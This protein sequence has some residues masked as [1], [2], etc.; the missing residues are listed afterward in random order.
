MTI[1]LGLDT[2]GTYTDAVVMDLETGKVLRK[3]KSQTT[4]EDLSIGIRNAISVL[5]IVGG[6]GVVSLSSTLATNSVVEGKGCRVALVC[7]GSEY[8]ESAPADFTFTVAGAHDLHGNE[9]EALD[10]DSVRGSL[11][12]V[13][14]RVDGVAVN[15]YMA[16][17]NPEHE[18]RVRDIAH[19]ILDVPVVCG[20][21]LSSSL[22]FNERAATCVMNAR[23]IPVIDELIRSVKEVM[24]EMGIHAP[25]MIV[26]GDGSMMSE[27]VARERPVETILSGPAA[28][29]IGA[30][31]LSGLRDA[32]VMD[33]G[34]TTTDIGVLRDGR[35]RLDRAGAIIGGKRTRVV[36][37]EIATSGIGGDSRVY[38]SGRN[39]RLS[40]LRV[41]PLC[42][43]AERWDCVR[44]H[45]SGL[46]ETDIHLVPESLS[47]ENVVLDCEMFRTLC[48]PKDVSVVTET[49]MDLL[50]LLSERPYSLSEAGRAL[51]VHPFAFNV[52][53][54]ESYGLIQRIGVTPTD[55]L[56]V[57]GAYHGFDPQP[58]I[59]GVSY[60]AR[61]SGKTME[62]FIEEASTAIRDKICSELLR[63]IL[64]EDA[65]TSDLGP[66]GEALMR[67]A[68]G[69][70]MEDMSCS[71][72]LS[73]PIIG[74]GAPAGVYIRWVGDVFGT[75]V[76][77]HPDSD[78]GNAVG[79]I[80]SSISESIEFLIRP[81]VTGD[82]DGK[83]EAF[84]RLGNFKYGTKAEAL[85]DCEARGR[86]FVEGSA[87]E[88]GA[89]DIYVDVDVDER[90]YDSN[91]LD[92]TVLM[93]IRMTVTAAGKPRQFSVQ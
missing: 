71:V 48:M 44:E 54:M 26:R 56:H 25:L 52:R 75:E 63:E 62:E 79:A 7:M 9:T 32:I 1:G 55:I 78:V 58:S 76:V 50:R 60:L 4:R 17:R 65:G 93:E 47:E 3:A 59:D 41:Y 2:G 87:S 27:S 72:R 12:S 23:L 80:A 68:I 24:S 6:V 84:S 19:G 10:E 77:I 61:R 92:S 29:L 21:E 85:E 13:R 69:H 20:H 39:V 16:V 51:G 73:R 43:A 5:G 37:A 8:D 82:D 88:S 31:H 83:F 46:S 11:E 18:R 66:A 57:S 42:M 81:E 14:G 33:M 74:I 64:R 90:R 70:G 40:S 34:G 91:M 38:I 86:A 15:G 89:S 35:P 30:M 45:L 28:S 22:G 49:D 53:R 36:A 67:V